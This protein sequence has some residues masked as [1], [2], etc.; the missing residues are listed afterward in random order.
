MDSVKF[1]NQLFRI[2]TDQDV[3]AV[4]D[5]DRPLRD[6]SKSNAGY[7][8]DSRFLLDS[9]RV[10]ENDTGL[11]HQP[12]KIKIAERRHQADTDARIPPVWILQK[13]VNEIIREISFLDA[14]ERTWMCRENYRHA[15][16]D[17]Q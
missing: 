14:L 7:P 8:E 16:R 17:F 1:Y 2:R 3:R 13:V 15:L 5:G 6:I 10:R 9:A 12:K 4:F 11:G